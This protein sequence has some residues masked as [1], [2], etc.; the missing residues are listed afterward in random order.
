M[1]KALI[2]FILLVSMTCTMSAQAPFAFTYQGVASDNLGQPIA[3][4]LLGIEISILK[5]DPNAAPE[6]VEKHQVRSSPTGHFSIEVGRGTFVSGT[7]LA[8]IAVFADFYSLAVSIDISGGENYEFLGAS[9]LL[10]VPYALHAFTAM[11]EPGLPGPAGLIG[12]AGEAG[13]PG[14][15]PPDSCCVIGGRQGDKGDP[16]PDGADGPQGMA[17]ISGLETLRLSGTAPESPQNGQ[18][19]LDDGSN[20]ADNRPGFRYFDETQWVDL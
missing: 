16:G 13:D 15:R 9:E 1:M 11:N 8:S 19:Y 2:Y 6:Y 18:I 17:G 14:I 4:Q 20:R 5:S 10:S 7:S 3:D 12:P